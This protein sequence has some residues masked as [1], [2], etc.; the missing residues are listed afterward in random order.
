MDKIHV[1]V[2]AA[3]GE[4]GL[5]CRAPM[6]EWLINVWRIL[7]GWLQAALNN[8]DAVRR[9]RMLP[10][11][12][13]ATGVLI[14]FVLMGLWF[15][16]TD[17]SWG[18]RWVVS[19]A[20]MFLV[21]LVTVTVILVWACRHYRISAAAL[22]VRP[23]TVFSDFRWSFRIC[24]LGAL[25]IAAAFVT[26][27]VAALGLGIRLPAPPELSVQFLAG[28]WSVR[29]S[30]LMVWLGVTGNM[31]VVVTE[32]LIYRSFFLPP[33]TSR[34]GLYPAVAVTAIVFGLAHVVPFGRRGIPVPEVIGGILMAGGF[35]IRWS[36][37]PAM[38]V[39]A[40]GNLFAGALVFTYV[41]LFRACPTLF[42]AQ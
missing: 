13:A 35:S 22:G 9:S 25:V 34:F 37:I 18:G 15:R 6:Q 17:Q 8:A 21:R 32:E 31:L 12:L 36:V 38:V 7:S 24:A 26:V 42:L 14:D 23:S 10:A 28:N 5:D 33:L 3:V 27:F 39:H 30:I 19:S 11:W 1:I 41:Q 40:M 2:R 20:M 29:Y 16:Y 4:L